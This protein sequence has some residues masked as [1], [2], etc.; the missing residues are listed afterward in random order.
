V[1]WRGLAISFGLNLL[2][3]FAGGLYFAWMMTQVRKKGYL[4][5]LNME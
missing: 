3:L 5:R 4:S 2:Y 1:G